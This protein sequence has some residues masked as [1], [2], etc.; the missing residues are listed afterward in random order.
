MFYEIK[1]GIL[2]SLHSVGRT[3]FK[4]Y[5]S[6]GSFAQAELEQNFPPRTSQF[7]S[8]SDTSTSSVHRKV[9]ILTKELKCRGISS[10][11]IFT[12]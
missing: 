10:S 12:N 7:D 2:E 8:H 5:R 11:K 1:E 6:V 4:I 3:W 9:L